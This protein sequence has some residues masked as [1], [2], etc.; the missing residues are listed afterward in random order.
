MPANYHLT[1][2]DVRLIGRFSLGR[3]G[4]FIPKDLIQNDQIH[5]IPY[6]IFKMNSG[7]QFDRFLFDATVLKELY[8]HCTFLF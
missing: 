3:F 8:V 1:P 5:A 6:T 7:K 2:P 4:W